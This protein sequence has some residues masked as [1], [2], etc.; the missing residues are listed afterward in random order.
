MGRLQRLGVEVVML[1]G[2]NAGTAAAIAR[3]AGATSVRAAATRGKPPAHPS[4][5]RIE[6]GLRPLHVFEQ[7][8]T[9]VGLELDAIDALDPLFDDVYTRLGD[10]GDAT[11]IALDAY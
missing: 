4:D 8:S 3:E 2:D 7:R 6:A 10:A 5:E 1:T 11:N 9:L